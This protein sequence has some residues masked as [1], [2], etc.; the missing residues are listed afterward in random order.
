MDMYQKR[1][2]R[3]E[4]KNNG[5]Q[6]SFSKVPISWYPGH[7]A[8]TKREIKEKIDLIDIVFEVVDARIPYSSK[9]KEIEEMTKGKPRVIVMTKIDL[10]DSGKTNK[11]IKYYE[12]KD[13]IV[14]PIDLINNP[15]T[16]IIFDKI[17]PLV[18]EIN[19]KR[20]S[21]GLKERKA[22]IL[23]MGVPNVG[24]STLINRLVGRK[25]TNVGNRPGVTKNLEWIR[26]NDKVELLDTPGI[27]WPKLDEEEV[28]YNLASMT[29]IKEEVL[30]SEDIAIYIIK[31]L[32]SDYPDNIINR[33]SLTKT[34]D[35]VDILD[36]IG[37]K[38]GAF[39][40]SETDYD[41]VYKRVI[42]DLQDGY[43]GKITFDNIKKYRSK[44]LYFY[45]IILSNIP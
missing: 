14:I 44:K 11:W 29:A 36:E 41:R 26:I 40:N 27:L 16:K 5:S 35:I 24:K 32:L 15:N 37:K 1:K 23:I 31:K 10:C 8:K 20:K 42:K 22:R 12:D 30:D 19:S 39:R 25:A 13:Y 7:M 17:K 4:K 28:A 18:D 38:I 21:K 6:E 9:N 3:Q 45:L 2:M 33:Y 34:E 43:L